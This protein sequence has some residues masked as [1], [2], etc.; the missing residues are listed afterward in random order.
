MEFKIIQSAISII[1]SACWTLVITSLLNLL[2]NKNEK[3]I[4]ASGK[5]KGVS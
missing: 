1:H 5:M 4:I 2:M 3:K